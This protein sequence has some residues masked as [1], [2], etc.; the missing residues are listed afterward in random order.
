MTG[1]EDA[2]LTLGCIGSC[3]RNWRRQA[4]TGACPT[5]APPA[6]WAAPPADGFLA[7]R[8]TA[9]AWL[10]LENAFSSEE[11]AG[12]VGRL[13]KVL[14]RPAP[15]GKPPAGACRWC[16]E[17]KSTATPWALS[18]RAWR[19]GAGASPRRTA[20][21]A[22][23]T[24]AT[25]AHNPERPL[26]PAVGRSAGVAWSARRS[27][28]PPIA[29]SRPSTPSAPAARSARLPTRRNACAPAPCVSSI[30]PW[31][32]HGD[33]KFFGLAPCTCRATASPAAASPPRPRSQLG[34]PEA[35]WRPPAIRLTP[36]CRALPRS[37]RWSLLRGMGTAAA[38]SVPTH[39][40]A[41]W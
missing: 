28:D 10:S 8:P 25:C 17:L 35:G 24:P 34:V 1:T 4:P 14:D 40:M 39:L 19:A 22:E 21:P 13:L 36:D 23:E 7:V 20:N 5:A 16:C 41:W 9:S 32:P 12:L 37:A 30:R 3:R 33:W 11:A 38:I 6:G 29:P 26:R 18:Y 31:W 2:V 27:P 15:L